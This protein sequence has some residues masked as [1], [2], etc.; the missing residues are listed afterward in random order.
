M[1]AKV[2]VNKKECQ[3]RLRGLERNEEVDDIQPATP[4]VLQ[5]LR[6]VNKK[7]VRAR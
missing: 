4:E 7:I 5:T 6:K 3:I 1:K 2:K